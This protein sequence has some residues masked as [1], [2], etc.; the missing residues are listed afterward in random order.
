ML[1]RMLIGEDNFIAQRLLAAMLENDGHQLVFASTS[2]E[3][4]QA[5]NDKVFD[6]LLLDYHLDRDA[7]FILKEISNIRPK[8]ALSIYIS[9]ASPETEVREKLKGLKFD[10]Y[11]PKSVSEG[12]LK[13]ILS[14]SR[15]QIKQK[16]DPACSNKFI[17]LSA[18]S[19]LMGNDPVKLDRIVSIFIEE[20]GQYLAQM[21][22]LMEAENF[23]GLKRTIHK[24]KAA[25]GYLGLHSIKR[26]LNNWESLI[27]QGAKGVEHNGLF[28]KINAEVDEIVQDLMKSRLSEKKR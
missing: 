23:E 22:Q 28:E 9:S 17:S 4:L 1:K 14:N 26:Q 18:L 24:A 6:I 11:I 19:N 16:P 13:K 20:S 12:D 2:D 3:I 27:E 25:Y 21:K 7:D 8:L 15:Y 5:L 10:G